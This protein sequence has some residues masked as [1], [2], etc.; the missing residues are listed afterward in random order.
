MFETF[1][2]PALYLCT[3]SQLALY[4]S[5]RTTGLVVNIGDSM[6]EIVPCYVNFIFIS[7]I[8]I[9]IFL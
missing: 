5:G 3:S 6:T 7:L 8:G 4:A 2:V 1:N 9:C